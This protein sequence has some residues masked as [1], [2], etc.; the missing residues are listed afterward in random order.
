VLIRRQSTGAGSAPYNGHPALTLFSRR[1]CV[2]AIC[3][4]CK[5]LLCLNHHSFACV[6]MCAANT[7]FDHQM[8]WRM[9]SLAGCTVLQ[10]KQHPNLNVC[11]TT[12]PGRQPKVPAQER[13]HTPR[14]QSFTL[15]LSFAVTCHIQTP[16]HSQRCDTQTK[17]HRQAS[18][19][20]PRSRQYSWCWWRV[21]AWSPAYAKDTHESQCAT[22]T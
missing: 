17:R 21:P 5:W 7:V 12:L 14:P 2:S 11:R 18:T 6:R 4:N 16:L 19:V 15:C 3:C 1:K 9:R 13:V 10:N 20:L 22:S 8:R